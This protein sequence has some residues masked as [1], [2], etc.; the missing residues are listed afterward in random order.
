MLALSVD[1]RASVANLRRLEASGLKG[2]MGFY[3][4][5]DDSRTSTREGVEGVTIYAYMA[6]HQ[7]MTLTA[8]DN[9]VNGEIIRKRFHSDPR[10]RAVESLLFE[11]IPGFAPASR[12][13]GIG[14]QAQA[15]CSSP[16]GVKGTAERTMPASQ[17]GAAADLAPRGTGV[18]R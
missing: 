8:L 12:V 9:L 7:G 13:K 3:E 2:P 15:A 14:A 18:T 5:I 4:A 16:A 6:H 1:S 17:H 11:R 10:I